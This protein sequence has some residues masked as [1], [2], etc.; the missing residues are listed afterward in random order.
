MSDL[1][2]LHAL[3]SRVGC[4]DVLRDHL[5]AYVRKRGAELAGDASRDATLVEDLI[6]F[7]E[8]LNTVTDTA[9]GKR[10]AF[11]HVIQEAFEYFL[12]IRPNKPAELIAKFL[13][14][15]L[16][17]GNKESSE[18]ELES[19]LDRA[20][21]L[22]RSI[23]GK[24]VFEAF[25]KKDLAKRLLMAKSAS[26]DLEKVLLSK[27]KAEC[28]SQFTNNLE[29]MF[30]DIE[31]SRDIMLSF[32]EQAKYASAVRAFDLDVTVLTAGFWPT[33]LPVNVA[34]PPDMVAAQ[35]VFS[36]FYLSKHGGRRLT[37]QSS[38]GTCVIKASFRRGKKELSVSQF[39]ALVLLLFNDRDT[40]TFAE[41]K[42]ALSIGTAPFGP[43]FLANRVHR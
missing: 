37:F 1:T 31:L 34:L 38:L 23:H 9:F 41:I 42:A 6:A 2:V 26:A 17:Q 40:M 11:A 12:N 8:R 14:G 33:Y 27:L 28:G 24:D 7:K 20:L 21:V 16:R 13:D 30:R 35:E 25:Y 43:L 36:Q 32:K 5:K 39:Q 18:Q 4:T 3:L 15:K 10:E 29:G 19:L 22:F